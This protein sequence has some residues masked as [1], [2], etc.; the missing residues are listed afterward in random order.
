MLLLPPERC[1]PVLKT[2]KY[3]VNKSSTTPNQKGIRDYL[4]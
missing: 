4:L 3:L 2:W 1:P